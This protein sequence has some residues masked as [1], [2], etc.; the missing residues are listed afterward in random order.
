[1]VVYPTT[2]SGYGTKSGDQICTEETPLEPITLYGRTKVQAERMI[3][4][5]GNSIT[6]R[7][8]TVF[9]VS[10]RMRTDLLVNHSSTRPSLTGTWWCSRGTTSETTCI[11]RT[12]PICFLH[13]I[14]RAPDMIGQCYNFGLDAANLS[15]E[16]LALKVRDHVPGFVIHFADIGGDPDQRNYVVSS[17][18][19]RDAG[20]AAHRTLD[21]GIRELMQAYRMMGRVLSRNT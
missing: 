2:N 17:A 20:M 7:L 12:S 6:L 1:M 10:P 14:E 5:A 15:K 4:E 13:C 19:L 3:L 9:G 8:A 16:E 18:K 21:A 11:S